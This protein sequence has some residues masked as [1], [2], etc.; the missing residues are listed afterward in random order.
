MKSIL[1]TAILLT[2]LSAT[3]HA[4]NGSAYC[5][6]DGSGTACPCA[7]N[8][9]SGEGCLN[10]AGTGGAS[11]SATG[12]AYTLSDDFQLHVSGVPGSRP[13]LIL[14][15]MNQLN[16]GLGSPVADGLLCAGGQA[17]RSQVQVTAG[18]STTFANFQGSGFGASNYG[19]GT[20]TNYQ[21][22]YR[23]PQNS[24]S[25]AGFNFSNGWSVVWQVDASGGNTHPGMALIP[26]GSY[27]MGRHVGSG[28]GDELPLHTVN[29]QAFQLDVHEVSNGDYAVYLNPDVADFRPHSRAS[30]PPSR[31]CGSATP[32]NRAAA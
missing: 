23:D 28:N 31:V 14:Q 16:G 22:Y 8:G 20:I 11:L 32:S 6:G 15:G 30:A 19:V 7:A 12:S 27:S 17:L 25:G 13:G 3:L 9:N 2:A 5:F 24:C 1:S 10:S 21:F 26:A 18:G 29:L 4:Q